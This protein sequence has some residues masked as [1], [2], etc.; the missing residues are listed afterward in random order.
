MI[1]DQISALTSYASVFTG[2]HFPSLVDFILGQD[3]LLLPPGKHWPPNESFYANVEEYTTVAASTRSFETHQW[4]ADLQIILQGSECMEY[5]TP[6]H[7][8]GASLPAK[9]AGD[10]QFFHVNPQFVGQVVVGAGSFVYFPVGMPHRPS[11]DLPLGTEA[12]RRQVR[13]MVV[14][15]P[16]KN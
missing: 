2:I 12:S 10:Y 3:L 4:H 9:I 16:H 1:F 14:K 11:L 6:D 13:K 15:I 5:T 7:L 8:V